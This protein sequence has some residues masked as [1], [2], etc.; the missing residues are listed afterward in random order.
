MRD[1]ISVLFSLAFLLLL[2][3]CSLNGRLYNLDT[4]EVTPI[5]FTYSGSGHGTISGVFDS[6]ESFSGDYT[7]FA[8]PPVNWGAVYSS[9]YGAFSWQ[10]V[11]RGESMQQYGTAIA[12]GTEGFVGDCE[13]VTA[14][15]THGSGACKAKD[16]TRYKIIW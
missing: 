15:L 13:Y 7:T 11:N 14:S 4:G 6:G 5:K 8:H 16:G 1:R 12:S 2:T 10:Q 3:G 9:V